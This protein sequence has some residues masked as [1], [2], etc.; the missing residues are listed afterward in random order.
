[1][2]KRRA[3]IELD[4]KHLAHNVAEFKRMLPEDCK[5]M[6][7]VKANAYGHGAS[8]M[9]GELQ[10]LGIDA[11]CVASMEEGI[12]LRRDGIKGEILVLG[13]TDPAA[14]KTL[15]DYQITQTIID[16]EYGKQLESYA[17]K[18]GGRLPVHIGVDTGMHRLGIPWDA[19][20]R[21]CAMWKLPH[22]EVRGV[23]SHLCVS[24]GEEEKEIAFTKTQI[25]RF[26]ET[27]AYLRTQIK[28]PFA[29]HLQGSYGVL[30]Y[31]ECHYDYARVGIALYGILSSRTLIPKSAKGL[32]PVLSL[33]SVITSIREL[34]PGEGAGYGLD[35]VAAKKSRIAA[36]AIG[37]ADGIPRNLS[38][39]GMALLHGKRVPI[40]GRVCMDQLLLD[41][42]GVPDA[43]PEDEVLFIGGQGA[44]KI[45]AEEFAEWSDTISN[46]IVSRLGARLGRF[47]SEN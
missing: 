36:A 3:W 30:N 15:L 11:F 28:K 35:F 27:V 9:A 18:E 46:E 24:D 4:M 13:Y 42:T 5:M 41:V 7:A 21:I 34:N 20:E 26:N 29:A 33:H 38:G 43:A 47:V 40:V 1:M 12:E 22:L 14:A 16:E 31:P 19:H 44:E 2:E 39:R 25:A 23:Y 17:A 8:E 6:P 32:L 45:S 10:K 37:Y